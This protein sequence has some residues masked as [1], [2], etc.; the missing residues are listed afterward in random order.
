M[1]NYQRVPLNHQ[2][3]DHNLVLKPMLTWRSQKKGRWWSQ[4]ATTSP[5]QIG[6]MPPS[7]PP[8]LVQQTSTLPKPRKALRHGGDQGL[9]VWNPCILRKRAPLRIGSLGLMV[10]M[11]SMVRWRYKQSDTVNGGSSSCNERKSHSGAF[12]CMQTIKSK[13]PENQWL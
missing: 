10:D 7:V 2:K 12:S 9:V 1:L 8:H 5:S 3:L 4:R 11:I 13:T 6:R